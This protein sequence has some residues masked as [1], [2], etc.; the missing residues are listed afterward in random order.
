MTKNWWK[1]KTVWTAIVGG[2]FE[3][4]TAVYP[5]LAEYR[6][7]VLTLIGVLGL[8]FLRVG[9]GTAISGDEAK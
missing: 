6:E 8:I 3:A 7:P 2:L 4:G 1:S 9:V 5:P